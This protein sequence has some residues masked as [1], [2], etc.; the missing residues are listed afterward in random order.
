MRAEPGKR[1]KGRPGAPSPRFPLA[2][3]S[4]GGDGPGG[5]TEA[6]SRRRSPCPLE[7]TRRGVRRAG[8][9]GAQGRLA[10]CGANAGRLRRGAPAAI[11]QAAPLPG[12]ASPAR[13]V[14]W[15]RF[16]QRAPGGAAPRDPA[17]PRALPG[18]PP[19]PPRAWRAACA[20]PSLPCAAPVS[21][22]SSYG[23]APGQVPACC[24]GRGGAG[25]GAGR[26]GFSPDS[27]AT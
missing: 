27:Q 25:A 11:R 13:G 9:L 22:G 4:W 6:G 7:E 3:L 17:L 21:L 20:R 15:H 2:W 12:R 1:W 14:S 23:D 19:E 8:S 16:C 18:R 10:P 5:R 24:Q 26:G